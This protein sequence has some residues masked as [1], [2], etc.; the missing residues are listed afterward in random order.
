M[1]IPIFKM[2]LIIIFNHHIKML[3]EGLETWLSLC[4]GRGPEFSLQ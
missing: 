2:D 1:S 3:E 4:S